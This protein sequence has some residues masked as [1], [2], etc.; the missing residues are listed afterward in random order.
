M[1]FS[2]VIKNIFFVLLFLSLAPTLFENISKQYKNY[3]EPKTKVG[4]IS[5]DGVITNSGYHTK[6][7]MKYFKD[8]D[9]K[10]ILIKM[11]CQGSTTGSGEA[12]Y[13]EIKV[14]KQQYPHKPIITLVENIC[15][16]GGYYMAAATDYIIAPGSAMIGSIG[17]LFP[18]LF[19]IPKILEQY[20]IDYVPV[21]SGKYKNTTNPFI[22]MGTEQKQHL[23]EL[24]DDTY[25]QFVA[26]VAD[27]R[28]LSLDKQDEWAQG[29][30]FTGN[31]AHSLQLIDEIGS[32]SNAIKKI[33]EL[34]GITQEIEWVKPPKS[35]S[36]AQMLGTDVD[37]SGSAAVTRMMDSICLYLEQRYS[38]LVTR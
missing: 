10:A 36:L 32:L 38:G 33:K 18:Y 7:L 29:R 5:I 8:T 21:A 24:S 27:G 9:I 16:S 28:K 23:Q 15:A 35:T 34:A 12:L 13:N 2:N 1:Q 37:D 26:R 11:D 19:Q 14:L 20:N 3:I 17:V 4:V 6:Y 25:K 22:P 30:I 31:K